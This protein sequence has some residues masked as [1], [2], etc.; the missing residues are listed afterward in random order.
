[1][2]VVIW[3]VNTLQNI[4]DSTLLLESLWNGGRSWICTLQKNRRSCTLTISGVAENQLGICEPSQ[5]HFCSRFVNSCH[6]MSLLWILPLPLPVHLIW[7]MCIG[8]S[9]YE[10]WCPTGF[11][12]WS[13]LFSHSAKSFIATQLHKLH[14]FHCYIDE[15]QM[16]LSF[17]PTET[18]PPAHQTRCFNQLNS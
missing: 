4:S 17:R 16:Y 10:A 2:V 8:Y 6:S 14:N 12:P 11:H 7:K 15:A 5:T 3:N 18:F 1:M 13:S 9:V